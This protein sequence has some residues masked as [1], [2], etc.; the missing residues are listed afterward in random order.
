MSYESVNENTSEDYGWRLYRIPLAGWSEIGAPSWENVET[1]RLWLD[2]F[3]ADAWKSDLAI[4]AADITDATADGIALITSADANP[5]TDAEQSK[6][7]GVEDGA[8]VTDTANVD[9]AGAVMESDFDSAFSLLVQ[10]SGTGAPTPL[11]VGTKKEK[12]CSEAY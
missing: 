4:A 8:D 12:K 7:A 6:L 9:A 1:V 2:G 10:Q 11:S 3:D 5:F